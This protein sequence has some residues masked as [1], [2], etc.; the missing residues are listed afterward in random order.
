MGKQHNTCN[1]NLSLIS[2]VKWVSP[3]LQVE[4]CHVHESDYASMTSETCNE[5]QGITFSLCTNVTKL[6]Q[7]PV[8]KGTAYTGGPPG[9]DRVMHNATKSS[10][11]GDE[12]KRT[13]CRGYHGRRARTE[14]IIH[15]GAVYIGFVSC[16]WT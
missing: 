12:S 16:T 14:C 4:V 5:T 15:K 1:I 6:A 10:E 13:V 11:F 7:F 8:M 9:A 2:R 3:Y